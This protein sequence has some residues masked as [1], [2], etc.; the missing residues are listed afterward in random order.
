MTECRKRINR[1]MRVVLDDFND[2]LSN[3]DDFP[4]SNKMIEDAID[5]YYVQNNKDGML[6]FM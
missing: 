2:A 5:Q 1:D 3:Q 6:V 4:D